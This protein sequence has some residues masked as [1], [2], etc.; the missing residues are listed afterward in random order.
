MSDPLPHDPADT[1]VAGP[2][3]HPPDPDPQVR[4]D[5]LVGVSQRPDRPEPADRRLVDRDGRPPTLGRDVRNSGFLPALVEP[6]RGHRLRASRRGFL[7]SSLLAGA[8]ASAA[9]LTG[10]FGPAKRVEAQTGV[11]GTYPRRILTFCPPYNSN[12]N[13]QPGCG[14]SPICTDCCDRDGFFRNDPANGYSLYPG[15]CGDGDI[16]DGWLW[17]FNGLCGN[18]ASIEYRCSDGYVQTDTGPAPFI[19]R[20]VTDCEPLPAGTEPG[21]GADAAVQTSWRPA[22]GLETAVDNG[23]SV[24]VNGWVTDGSGSPVSLRVTANGRIVHL[25]PASLP[26]PDIAA[27]VRDAGPNTGFA[28]NFPLEPGDY[29]LCVDALNGAIVA[30]VGCVTLNVGSGQT[31]RGST[32]STSI[33]GADPGSEVGDGTDTQAPPA[34][35]PS[36]SSDPGEAD[37][38]SEVGRFVL[39]DPTDPTTVMAHGAVQVIRR[40]G[41]TTGFV[42]GWAGDPDTEAAPYV[43]VLVGDRAVA[44]VQPDLPRPDVRRAFPELGATSGFAVSFALPETEAEVCVEVVDPED[45]RRRSLGCRRLGASPAGESAAAP[46]DSSD[47]DRAGRPTASGEPTDPPDTV[48]GAVET[49]ELSAAGAAVRGW[50]HAPN[51]PDAPVEVVATTSSGASMAGQ[52]VLESPAARQRHGIDRPCGFEILLDLPSGEHTIRVQADTA[53]GTVTLGES[54]VSIP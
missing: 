49:V 20:W 14:S 9:A 8:A 22:G 38:D 44:L 48:W 36:G 7:R 2:V 23:G 18:C 47:A 32:T 39:A 53:S 46:Q 28:I 35:S 31:V 29:R 15:G 5:D 13:C 30:T 33:G 40:S 42:S 1:I 11:I 27:A 12:D 34:S 24:S 50:A 19:C 6:R 10:A 43:E 45:G 37:S 3:P 25:G 17:R 21:S 51:T 52:A 26:R 41:P 4:F 16:A 54:N